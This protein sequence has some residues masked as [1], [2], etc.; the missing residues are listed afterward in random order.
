MVGVF[1]KGKSFEKIIIQGLLDEVLDNMVWHFDEYIHCAGV[2]HMKC[3]TKRGKWQDQ[4]THFITSKVTKHTIT[5]L[6]VTNALD[7][8][9][10]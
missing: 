9:A 3:D 6:N 8:E 7:M 1:S 10:T 5:T 4:T 2:V